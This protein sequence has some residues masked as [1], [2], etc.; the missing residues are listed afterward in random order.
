MYVKN[1]DIYEDVVETLK[2]QITALQ[3]IVVW[4]CLINSWNIKIKL[5]SIKSFS[6]VCFVSAS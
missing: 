4:F 2:A 5:C 6:Y 1:M 3:L